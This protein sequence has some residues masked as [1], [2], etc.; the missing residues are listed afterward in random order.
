MG[1]GI[2]VEMIGEHLGVVYKILHL[3]VF[4]G[5]D[6]GLSVMKFSKDIIFGLK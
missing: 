1:L 6:G 3:C 5:W 4:W 2:E